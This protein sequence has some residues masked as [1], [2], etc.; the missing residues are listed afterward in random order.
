[1]VGVNKADQ[2]TMDLFIGESFEACYC[3]GKSRLNVMKDT[4]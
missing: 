2:E 4:L 1:M 3:V